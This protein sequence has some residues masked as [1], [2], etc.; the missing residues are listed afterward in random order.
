MNF[1]FV[2]FFIIFSSFLLSSCEVGIDLNN[3]SHEIALQPSV[4]IPIGSASVSLGQFL[5][6]NINNPYIDF[7]DSTEL[8]YVQYDSTEISFSNLNLPAN[9]VYGNLDP[10]LKAG[11]T[12][13]QSWN[14]NKFFPTGVLRFSN[15][16]VD[17]NLSSNI[18]SYLSFQIDYIKAFNSSD[19]TIATYGWF[20]NHTTTILSDQFDSKPK[21]PGAWV[22]KS[23]P[24]L[25]KDRGE[26]NHLFDTENKYNQVQYKFSVWINQSLVDK[27]V[28]PSFI[29][30]DQKI[31]VKMTTKI[32]FQF[33]AGSFYEY[34]DTIPNAF[35]QIASALS[36]YANNSIDTAQIVM[37]IKN[38]LPVKTQ[39]SLSFLDSLGA[40]IHT[41]FNEVYIVDA[42]SVDANGIVKTGNEHKEVLLLSI[43]KSQLAMLKTAR[44][45]AY[46]VRFDGQNIG[47]NIHF[48][49]S[50]TFD[51]N[52]GLFV[53]ADLSGNLNKISQN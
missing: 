32:P 44:K 31:K 25:N 12:Y 18:G 29:T 11:G 22:T 7:S 20:N 5:F 14:F 1:K 21:V 53:K 15:P 48:T 23:L 50:N 43:T 19:T 17:V 6:H 16:T 3:I 51:L 49:K 42:G 41:D 4:V 10:N 13:M 9:V 35:N 40:K 39:L 8:S 34:F 47:A 36:T 45:M 26:T 2:I 46:A 33:D 30:S 27:D 24:T 37:N 28:T 38:G 52:V